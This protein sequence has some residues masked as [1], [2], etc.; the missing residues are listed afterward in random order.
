MAKRGRDV[1]YLDTVMTRLISDET[2]EPKYGSHQLHGDYARRWECYI[3]PDF[4]L[5]W[6]YTDSN[7]IVFVRTGTHADLFE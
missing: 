4:L 7:E 3:E 5:I 2:L 6:H 1:G